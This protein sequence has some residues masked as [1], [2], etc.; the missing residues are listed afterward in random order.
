MWMV[1]CDGGRLAEV[2]LEQGIVAIGWRNV[3]SLQNIKSREEIIEK[4]KVMWPEY[5]TKKSVVAG[6][7]LHKVVFEMKTG[8][9]VITYDKSKDIYHI[10]RVAGNYIFERNA[11]EMTAHRRNVLWEEKI[12]RDRLSLPTKRFLGVPLSIFKISKVAESEIN[13]LT[14]SQSIKIDQV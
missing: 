12:D 8:D 9:R 3:G 14:Q 11:E 6:S 13:A 10:G 2:F 4:I 1:R 5:K 7:Q